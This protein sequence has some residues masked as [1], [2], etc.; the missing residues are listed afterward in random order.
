[1]ALVPDT[2]LEAV[3]RAFAKILDEVNKLD[4]KDLKADGAR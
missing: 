3:A 2:G 4:I 1:M